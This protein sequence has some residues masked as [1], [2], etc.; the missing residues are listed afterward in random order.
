MRLH[1]LALLVCVAVALGLGCAHQRAAASADSLKTAHES[2]LRFLRWSVLRDAS[3]ILVP[4]SEKA[5]LD[6]ALDAKDDENLKIIDYELDDLKMRDKGATTVTQ[7]TWHRLP[8]VTTKRERMTVE[9]VE[10][11]GTWYVQSVKGGPLPLE[12]APEPPRCAD[13]GTC[14]P[15]ADGAVAAP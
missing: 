5:W 4:E 8:S 15:G 6:G 10:R 1:R 13:G 2:F 9:W 14:A 12:A 7:L 3:Q 11:G